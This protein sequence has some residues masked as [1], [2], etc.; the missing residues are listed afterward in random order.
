MVETNKEKF[1]R[2]YKFPKD[3]SHSIKKISELT[4]FQEAGLRK[5]Y[6][7]GLAAHRNNPQSV[8]RASDFKKTGTKTLKGKL[9]AQQWAQARVYSAVMGGP[10]KK[11]DKDLLKKKKGR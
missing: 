7:K 11:Y 3:T 2:K 4:G 6:Q 1:N 9:S 10:A 5:I 8:R